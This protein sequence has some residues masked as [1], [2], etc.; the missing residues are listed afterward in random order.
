MKYVLSI[1]IFCWIAAG[2][3]AQVNVT[4]R[5]D[6]SFQTVH[7]SGVHL[8]GSFQGWNP[9]GTPLANIGNGIWELTLPLSPNS[10][11][12]YKFINGNAW[13]Q[14]EGVP[15]DCSAN[16]NRFLNTGGVNLL[17]P[18]VCFAGCQPCFPPQY[19][20]TLNVDMGNE[21]IDQ[22]GVHI[23]GSFQG[24]NP[25]AT[26]M[27]DI[28]NGIWSYTLSLAA[29]S[30]FEYKFINGNTWGQ[31]ESV[32]GN[33]NM[34]G[35]RFHTSGGANENLG[36]VCFGSCAPCPPP[37]IY[38]TFQ[39]DMSLETV[40]P[41]G[42][43]I[44]GTFQGWNPA[45]TPMQNQGNGLWTI[46]IPLEQG[47]F[48]EYK[49]INGN[50]WGLEETLLP[51]CSFFGN[52]TYTAG[53]E[54]DVLPTVCFAACEA[55]PSPTLYDVTFQVDMSQQNLDPAGAF[56]AGSFNN[57]TPQPMNE[58]GDGIWALTLNLVEGGFYEF[59]YIN[60]SDPLNAEDVPLNCASNLNRF[61]SVP[62]GS[63]VLEPACFGSCLSCTI[64]VTFRVD[65]FNESTNPSGIH[66]AG[67][68]QG[69][70][71][72]GTPMNYLGYGIWEITVPLNRFFYYEYKFVNGNSW[73][74]YED[75]PVECQ[76]NWNRFF[77]TGASSGAL[78]LVCFGSCSPCSGC[79]DP[80]SL[81]FNPFAESDNGS[82][83]A[84]LVWGCTYD[85]ASNYNPNANRDNGS[86]EFTVA[87]NCPGDVTGDG[88]VNTADLLDILSVFG[89]TCP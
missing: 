3:T 77:T 71:P 45:A 56:L 9:G 14:D 53:N 24:W 68:F 1:L 28:G 79:T 21:A 35:N 2:S 29:G 48:Y 16:N 74:N 34:N 49:F 38:V 18:T 55:C 31:D 51:D 78:P 81:E 66:L 39:V 73:N 57:W 60:G 58:L 30:Y 59:K 88:I 52:R 83:A 15:G 70:D 44:A 4:F 42:V 36:T 82:C 87:P 61:V 41:S 69:W 26:P 85:G 25:G 76:T 32:P 11:Y 12:E 33:C 8:A 37:P 47:V 7:P 65:M 27:T 72:S 43:H 75:V 80:L 67:S 54:E 20:I 86:C 89:S 50:T 22:T 19:E 46:S 13:G 84:P 63:L 6:M 5:V 23:A 40:H 10:Y 64:D 17:I 62:S